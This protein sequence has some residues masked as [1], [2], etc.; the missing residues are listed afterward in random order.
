MR[1]I[2]LSSIFFFSLFLTDSSQTL[3]ELVVPVD[4]KIV[5]TEISYN[6]PEHGSDSLE[7][8]EL[9]NNDTVSADLENF[10]FSDGVQYTFPS[11]VA[12]PH[13]YILVAKSAAAML[14]TFGVTALQWTSGA[15]SNS[16]ELIRLKDGDNNTV[17]SV[18]YDTSAPWD[19]LANGKGPSLELCDPDADNEVGTNWR[20]AI[21]F[22]SVNADGDSIWGSPGQGCSYLPVADF[23]ASDTVINTGDSVIFTSTSEG[24]PN[25]WNWTFEG[26]IPGEFSGEFPSPIHYNTQ[27]SY[28]VTLGVSNSIGQTTLTRDNYITVGTTGISKTGH[29]PFFLIC[30][31]PNDGKFLL[32]LRSCHACQVTVL[33]LLGQVVYQ[34]LMDH[35][36]MTMD[37]SKNPAGVYFIRITG[38][39][40]GI[41]MTRKILIK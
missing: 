14:N 34:E 33:S 27:G 7:Y 6:P 5:I 41:Q 16:G 39:T 38:K 40:S 21:E 17:D 26:G 23:E 30:P 2:F 15:L 20:H 25:S 10:H 18:Y 32:I 9:Y 31:N 24:F 8:I 1:K 3:T 12:G 22:Q 28:S 4:V 29:T 36:K 19:S 37:L 13:S 11:Y 35:E